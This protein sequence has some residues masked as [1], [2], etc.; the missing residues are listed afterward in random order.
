MKAS[1]ASAL[2]LGLVTGMYVALGWQGL[3]GFM[4]AILLLEGSFRIRFGYW[5]PDRF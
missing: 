4:I 5:R 2:T 1:L 3:A